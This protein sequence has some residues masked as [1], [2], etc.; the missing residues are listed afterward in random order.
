MKSIKVANIV[1]TSIVI[2]TCV[3]TFSTLADERG[4]RGEGRHKTPPPEAIEAC[5]DKTAGDSVSFETKRGD[6]ITGVCMLV[7]DQLVA[8]PDDHPLRHE[9]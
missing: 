6:S 8:I 3:L 5:V 7:D 2:T 1:K 4:K 9:E